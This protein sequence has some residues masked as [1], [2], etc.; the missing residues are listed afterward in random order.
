MATPTTAMRYRSGDTEWNALLRLA[1]LQVWNERCYWC[2]TKRDFGDVDID[3]VIPRSLTEAERNQR[4][5]QL[6]GVDAVPGF[7]VDALHNLAPICHSPCNGEKTDHVYD[8]PRYLEILQRVKAKV[9][10]VQKFIRSF[11]ASGRVGKA[12]VAV[13][14][15]DLEDSRSLKALTEFAPLLDTRLRRIEFTTIDEFE[16]P[17]TDVREIT[18][19]ELDQAG[20]RVRDMMAVLVGEDPDDVLTTPV[21]TVKQEISEHLL[22]DIRS[23]V[24]NAGHMYPEIAPPSTRIDLTITE[25]L[26]I[27]DDEQFKMVGT[28]DADGSSH[29]AVMGADGDGLDYLQY[30]AAGQGTFRVLFGFNRGG[31]ESDG[32][33]YLKW[34]KPASS[35]KLRRLRPN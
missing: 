14:R 8:A 10:E 28:F 12:L 29:A 17:T 11:E 1:L 4:V 30:D 16:D 32:L 21:L 5:E 2:K 23:Q 27:V 3:H 20:R 13:M 6:L 26:Y 9:P 22:S 7:D 33:V 25:L 31:L 34:K 19:V 18:V 24:D 15:T 35:R